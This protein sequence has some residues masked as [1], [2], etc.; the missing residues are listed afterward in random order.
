ME[1]ESDHHPDHRRLIARG[2]ARPR[3]GSLTG[4]R[5]SM[6]SLLAVR[7]AGSC[8]LSSRKEIYSFMLPKRLALLFLLIIVYVCGS[9]AQLVNGRFVTSFYTWNNFD[10][11]GVSNT[12]L[13]AYQTV[14]FSA[15]QGDISLHTFL[16]GA[17]NAVGSF[18]DVG[19]VRFYNMFLSWNN[20][21]NAVDLDL[22][23]QAIYGGVGSGTIDGLHAR[24]RLWQDRIT[25]TGFGG[26][27]V[28][29]DFT[30]VQKGPP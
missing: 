13:R 25:V 19:R 18:G 11:V 12:R 8:F 22:G 16:Q 15:A 6:R 20:I 26:A 2:G 5:V 21:G 1:R 10:T 23:R 14:Q 28:N 3:R 17:M 29:D 30:G 9:D 4:I 27:T 7:E 24:A